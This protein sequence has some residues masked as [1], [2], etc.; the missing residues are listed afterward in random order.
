MKKQKSNRAK[1][2]DDIK[3]NL[4]TILKKEG[5]IE[6]FEFR[7]FWC[8]HLDMGLRTFDDELKVL[9]PLVGA[10]IKDGLIVLKP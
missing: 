1:R 7:S 2:R 5:K 3:K 8:Y 10:K 9:L 4:Q 6:L